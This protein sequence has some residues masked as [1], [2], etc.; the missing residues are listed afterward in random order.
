MQARGA[1]RKDRNGTVNF[2]NAVEGGKRIALLRVS[3]A[4]EGVTTRLISVGLEGNFFLFPNWKSLA[5]GTKPTGKLMPGDVFLKR[6]VSLAT[7]PGEEVATVNSI[8]SFFFH[9]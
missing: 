5:Q 3:G 8:L 6:L 1:I 9:S 2:G 4:G 7:M